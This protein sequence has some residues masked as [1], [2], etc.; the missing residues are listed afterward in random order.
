MLIKP[1]QLCV[2]SEA[3]EIVQDGSIE[4]L[5]QVAIEPGAPVVDLDLGAR[6]FEYPSVLHA[7][8]ASGFASAAAETTV[9]MRDE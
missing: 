2:A 1:D 7:G 3:R 8:W 9:E 5:P 6:P 4:M